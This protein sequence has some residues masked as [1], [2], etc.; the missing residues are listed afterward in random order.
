MWHLALEKGWLS[1][2]NNG[3]HHK[4][5]YQK[6]N[7]PLILSHERSRAL[8]A[9][10]CNAI[11]ADLSELLQ[12][13]SNVP[14]RRGVHGRVYR[15]SF[16]LVLALVAILSGASKF[17]Q[18]ADQAAD[19]PQEMLHKLGGPWCWF[20]RRILVPSA[21]TIRLALAAADADKL[22]ELVGK[23]LLKY[24]QESP[25]GVIHLCLDGKVLRGVRTQGGENFTL[26]SA[27]SQAEG[28]TVAQVGVPD[29]TNETTQVKALLGQ[30]E[31]DSGRRV[32][33]TLDAA[34][35]GRDTAR[36]ITEERGFDY[37][38]T[39][40]GNRA[41][42]QSD[43]FGKTIGCTM[44]TPD[45]QAEEQGH[46]RIRQWS[47]WVTDAEGINFPGARQVALIKREEFTLAKQRISKEIALIVTSQPH[48]NA[49]PPDMHNQV[50]GHWAIENKSHY[51]RDVV[52]HEDAHIT[53]SKNGSRTMASLRNVAIGL[54]RIAGHH[55]IKKTTEWI[56]RDRTRALSVLSLSATGTRS[57]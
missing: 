33:V 7:H 22:D 31:A 19:L 45:H 25:G 57:G 11:E 43:V 44:R 42:L 10:H 52:F 49:T 28:V 20:R 4:S 50:R 37:V 5:P 46:G 51:V 2:W 39:V 54:L 1:F 55:E 53:Y 56:C 27:M 47:T 18:I 17:R 21:S 48:D 8:D 36:Y 30:F 12:L 38:M 35:T 29:G 23:W 26:F 32:I 15:L 14:D 16:I 24:S 13:L 9:P 41:E 6:E 40:K 34:H 3:N